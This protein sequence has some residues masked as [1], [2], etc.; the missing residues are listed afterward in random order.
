MTTSTKKINNILTYLLPSLL[1]NL[2]PIFT[3]PILTRYLTPKDFGI[4]ALTTAFTTLIVNFLFCNVDVATQRYYFDYRKN[5]HD[6]GS[7]INSGLIFM[8]SIFVLSLP[9]MILLGNTISNMVLGSSEYR[10]I[11][12][13]AYINSG[14]LLIINYYLMLYK[15]MENAKKFSIVN[16]IQIVLNTGF[17]LFFI[18]FLK[19]GYKGMIYGNLLS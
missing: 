15:N 1:S 4:I 19:L 18:I 6:L 16:M 5:A 13:I 14:L 11:I 8:T 17:N 7:L 3:L 10:L 12:T 2:L 9:F